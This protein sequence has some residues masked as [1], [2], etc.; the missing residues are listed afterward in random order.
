M[1]QSN[2]APAVV[3]GPTWITPTE[4]AEIT[5]TPRPTV[6][7]WMSKGVIRYSRIGEKLYIPR[8]VLEA[9]ERGEN[10]SMA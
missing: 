2:P 1:D 10:V 8:E 5:R 9:F 3:N 7:G 4:F 6:Y